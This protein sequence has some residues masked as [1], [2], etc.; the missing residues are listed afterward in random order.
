[1]FKTNL[2]LKS[3]SHLIRKL[4]FNQKFSSISYILEK[5]VVGD[6]ITVQVTSN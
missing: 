6:V 3:V 2:L 4:E 5:K 1:M